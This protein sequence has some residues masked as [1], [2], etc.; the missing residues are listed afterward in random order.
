[1]EQTFQLGGEFTFE[2]VR[3][4]VVID[5]WS[6][7]NLVVN[8]GLNDLLQVH[9]G[10]GSQ[11]SIWYVGIFAGNYTPVSSLTAATVAANATESVAYDEAT[12]PEWECA[13]ASGQ[14]ITNTANKATFTMND[15]ATIYGAFLISNNEKGGTGGVLFAASRFAVARAVVDEDQLLVTYTVQAASA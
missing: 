7:K 15:G 11:K 8:E 14:Q 10:D 3:G 12:R 6:S 13:A 2:L 1:M 9:L 5:K 4:G